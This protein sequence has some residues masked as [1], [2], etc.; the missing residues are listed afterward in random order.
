MG[1]PPGAVL[2]TLRHAMSEASQ[3]EVLDE[4]IDSLVKE[5]GKEA[6]EDQTA[7]DERSFMG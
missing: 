3:D 4:I 7:G 5:Q 6:V 1:W 2:G